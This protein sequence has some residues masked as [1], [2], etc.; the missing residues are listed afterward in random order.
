M[1][2]ISPNHEGGT[3]TSA[4]LTSDDIEAKIVAVD[5]TLAAL[6]QG[7][8][9]LS[10]AAV[11]GDADAAKSLA[12][13]NADIER[14]KADREVLERARRTAVSLEASA[15]DKA[16]QERRQTHYAAACANARRL[17]E[18]S[19]DIDALILKFGSVVSDIQTTEKAIHRELGGAK[20]SPNVGVVG[21]Q[22]LSARAFANVANVEGVGDF[23]N[24][25]AVTDVARSAWGF[26]LEAD[27]DVDA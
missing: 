7:A 19:S 27:A 23:A 15:A 18:L 12:K 9:R 22:N 13:V 3:R 20:A 25:V 8:S 11:S 16:E 17:V 2:A 6:E 5:G 26:L 24:K 4:T 10:Y 14:A 1:N 21:R